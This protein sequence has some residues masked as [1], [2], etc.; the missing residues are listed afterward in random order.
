VSSNPDSSSALPRPQ[1]VTPAERYLK[2]LCDHTFLTMWSHAGPYREPGKELCDLLVVFDNHIIIFSDKD[3]HFTN[4]GD[5]HVDWTRWLRKAVFRSADQIWGAERWLKTSHGPLFLDGACTQP[6]PYSLPD[7]SVTRFHRIVVAHEVSKQCRERLGGS[8]SLMI[9]SSLEGEQH[10]AKPEDGGRLFT[11]G[12]IDRSKGFVHIF[13]DTSLEIVIETLDTITDFVRYLTNKEQFLTSQTTIFAAGEEE[14]LALYLMN[15][16]KDGE[17]DLVVNKKYQAAAYE[18]GFWAEFSRTE[19]RR[20]QIEAD[21]VS[22]LWDMLIER[23]TKN[24]LN[25]TLRTASHEDVGSQEKAIRWLARESRFRRRML[26]HGLWD[27]VNQT[28]A[29]DRAARIVQPLNASD[30]HYVFLLL[31]KCRVS[32]IMALIWEIV[33]MVSQMV[34]TTETKIVALRRTRRSMVCPLKTKRKNWNC[35][36]HRCSIQHGR[37]CISQ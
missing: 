25:K 23:F 32:K 34:A 2:K 29:M 19:A 21:K 9:D 10:F 14:L 22:Y 27:L 17:R 6:F 37:C 4:S 26:A 12:H 1:G 8:G 28:P 30:P 20:S 33:A 24:I 15:L 3:C 31:R 11:V 13:D 35:D 18:E 36:T 16:N 5:L 7:P